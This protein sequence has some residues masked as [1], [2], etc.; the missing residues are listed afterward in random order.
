MFF[1]KRR[2]RGIM[3]SADAESRRFRTSADAK[4]LPVR[5]TTSPEPDAGLRLRL[6]FGNVSYEEDA[7]PVRRA[8]F[9]GMTSARQLEP[10][11]PL[12]G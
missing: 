9:P 12:E 2:R 6:C 3:L 1:P 7:V 8:T 10:A 5:L 11:V 4:V